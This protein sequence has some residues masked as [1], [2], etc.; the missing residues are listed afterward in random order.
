MPRILEP[1]L[2]VVEEE[3]KSYNAVDR[4]GFVSLFTREL[5]TL[6]PS[7]YA[8]KTI[9]DVGCGCGDFTLGLIKNFPG[10]SVVAV[11]GS[12]EMLKHAKQKTK[13]FSNISF[14]HTIISEENLI[15]PEFD[16][17]VSTLTVHHCRNPE[18][19]LSCLK[20]MAKP[21][22]YV[23]VLDIIREE[24]LE[25]ISK[26]V[27]D[28]VKNYFDFSK[29]VSDSFFKKSFFDSLRAALS[30]EEVRTLCPKVFSDYK[31][32]IIRLDKGLN[33][34]FLFAKI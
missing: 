5:K 34:F 11:D 25:N 8:P 13:S 7:L 3:A 18:K 9:V 4:N 23:F 2:M 21:N 31:I 19:F 26:I 6:L 33:L 32:K 27:E 1:E 20:K 15:R 16:L 30:F 28:T 22:G 12:L 14:L 29:N 24:D 10:S 17:V